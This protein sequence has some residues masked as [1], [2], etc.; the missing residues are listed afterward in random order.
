[1][2]QKNQE[3]VDRDSMVTLLEVTDS[4]MPSD[5]KINGRMIIRDREVA[6][7]IDLALDEQF[8]SGLRFGPLAF[9]GEQK[10]KVC[11]CLIGCLRKYGSTRYF[12]NN[13]LGQQADEMMLI[14]YRA[15]RKNKVIRVSNMPQESACQLASNLIGYIAG[16]YPVKITL[17]EN[18][19]FRGF[20]S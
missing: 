4:G 18:L 14:I 1:M 2:F 20:L 7:I 3:F 19:V 9:D 10:S 17:R 11:K 15:L 5:A 6:K 13:S 8:G 16:A 12:P